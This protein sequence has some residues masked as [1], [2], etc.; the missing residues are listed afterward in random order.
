LLLSPGGCAPGA[1]HV[2]KDGRRRERLPGSGGKILD[3]WIMGGCASTKD[4]LP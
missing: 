3:R 1:A 4:R 2:S